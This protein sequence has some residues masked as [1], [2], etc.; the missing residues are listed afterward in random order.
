MSTIGI[1]AF[2]SL[3]KDPGVE[4]GP[5]IVSRKSTKTPFPVEFGRLSGTRGDAP[6]LVPHN[7]GGPVNAQVLVL[8]NGVTQADARDM[9][10]RRET[11][12]ERSGKRYPGGNSRNSVVVAMIRDFEGIAMVLY[13][14]FPPNGKVPTP[15]PTMLAEKAIAS[16]AKA[17]PGMDGISYLLQ[18]IQSGIKTPLTDEYVAEVLARTRTRSLEE[19]RRSRGDR[20]RTG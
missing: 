13:T 5:C 10:W 8:E 4:I 9:L 14:D 11:R 19:A 15:S 6:T 3:I 18:A 1:L 7:Q 17:K 20:N 16:V 12:N 2:G